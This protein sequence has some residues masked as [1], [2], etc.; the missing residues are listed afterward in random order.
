MRRLALALLIVMLPGLAAGQALV[1][2]PKPDK[3]AVTVYRA[4][5]GGDSMNLNWLN[6]FAMVSETRRVTLPPGESELRFEGVAGGLVPQSAVVSLPDGAL[7]EKNRDAKLLSPGTLLEAHLGKRVHLRRTSQATGAV[8]EQ[9]AVILASG[10]GVVLQTE[11]GFEALHCTGLS[12]TL[13][14]PEVPATLAAKPTLSVRVRSER[15]VEGE[16]TLTYLSSDF[17][18]RAHYVATLAPSGRELGL[19]AW[20]TLANGDE[21]GFANAE[22]MAVA[23]RLNRQETERLQPEMRP[24]HLNCWPSQRSHEI[25]GDERGYA[26]QLPAPPPPPPPPPPMP[27]RGGD[28]AETI[29]VTGSRIMAQRE[30]LGDLKLYRIPIPV[31]VAS[32]SQKQVALLDQPKARVERIYR[33]RTYLSNGQFEPIPAQ[34]ILT[35]ENREKDG[36]G[37]PLPAGGFT[38]YTMRGGRPFLL[39]EGGMTDR[40]VGEKVEVVLSEAPGVRVSHRPVERE[41][42]LLVTELVATNDQPVPV[43]FEA[44]FM[45]EGRIVRSTDKLLRR[46]GM[47][48]WTVELPA[49][50]SRTLRVRYRGLD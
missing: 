38:L 15:P 24:I 28:V 16:V 35:M 31:T 9:E 10:D 32:N 23:G 6:G 14:P 3:V 22:T 27:E 30:D 41:G 46:D 40:A 13:L 34:Q 12:E 49:N 47:W 39:G 19:F 2:S 29:T 33:L 36:L 21:T 5:H 4:P 42:D 17:D 7:L 1:V 11:T 8:R 25:P 37:L 18:W 45:D 20:L 44:Q 50:G 48:V 26:G 43:R